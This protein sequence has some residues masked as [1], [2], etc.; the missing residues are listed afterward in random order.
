MRLFALHS[1]KDKK[2]QLLSKR[3]GYY[4]GIIAEH[5]AEFWLSLKGYR[6]LARRFKCNLGEIDLVVCTKD[7]LIAVEVKARGEKRDAIQSLNMEQRDRISRALRTFQ[8]RYSEQFGNHSLRCDFFVVAL[9]QLPQHI[10]NAWQF[11]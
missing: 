4:F 6:I 8:A 2:K 5:Y 1:W 7:T 9:N 11:K 10:Q 3:L